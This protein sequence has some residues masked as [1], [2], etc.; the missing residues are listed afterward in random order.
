MKL[1]CETICTT[2]L[3]VPVIL[4]FLYSMLIRRSSG[5]FIVPT[6]HGNAE[7]RYDT[8]GVPTVSGDTDEAVAFGA[9]W[10]Q[11]SDRLWDMHLK[12]LLISGRISEVFLTKFIF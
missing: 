1:N 6:I 3:L 4:V 7:I 9:G 8:H 12:R 5:E 2:I 10:A 11:A